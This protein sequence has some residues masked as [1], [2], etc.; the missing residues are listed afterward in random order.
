[1][2]PQPFPSTRTIAMGIFIL[3]SAIIL[4]AILVI[5]PGWGFM[6]DHSNLRISRDFWG[7]PSWGRLERFIMD[8]ISVGCFRPVYKL[9]IISA[10]KIAE[11]APV[12]IY[13]FT[14]LIG[15][16]LLPLW[17]LILDNAFNQK[18]RDP[19][20]IWVYP[21]S[22]FLFTPFW[23]A[24]MYISVQ[25]RFIYFFS[26]P[27][28]YFFLKS[29]SDKKWQ[30]FLLSLLFVFLAIMAKATG[31]VL[32]M[33]FAAYA[34]L[35]A[36]LFKRQARASWMITAISAAVFSGYYFFI[37]STLKNYTAKYASNSNIHSI[38]ANLLASP[39]YIKLILFILAFVI[40]Y[41]I[42]RKLIDKDFEGTGASLFAW[43][44]IFYILI[45][46]PWGFQT[47]LLSPMA[48]FL[49]ATGV[50]FFKW[51]D[52]SPLFKR[53]KQISLVILIFLVTFL[54]IIPQIHKMAD[55]RKVAA[56]VHSISTQDPSAVF[57]YPR[58]YEETSIALSAFSGSKINY[59]GNGAL[60]ARDIPARTTPYL[61]IN[62]EC[63]PA[64]LSDLSASAQVYASS[65]WAIY[66]LKTTPAQSS[67][68]KPPFAQNF[69]QVLKTFIKRI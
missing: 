10:Y 3:W 62:D 35:D 66:K 37:Q 7:D 1:M 59:L 52:R 11:N 18:K 43:L 64:Q 60:T 61:L 65:T 47:Y 34:F 49:M 56:Q 53:I 63:A 8:D 20:L 31:I 54:I 14:T 39:V 6:D 25:E 67:S 5:R 17:G 2:K 26:T 9:W 55:K 36:I 32:I 16:A 4:T 21:L 22:F 23:N 45:L 48:P 30:P 29:Y 58:P 51:R 46:T 69:I 28:I 19:F 40:L 57:F 41:E 12:L 42:F 38:L 27:A 13:F 15:L 44:T 50:F 68:F 24:F 33:G